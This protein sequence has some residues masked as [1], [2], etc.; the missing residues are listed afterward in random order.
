MKILSSIALSDNG[1]RAY[2]GNTK[3][4]IK[5]IMLP[6]GLYSEKKIE[7]TAFH[8]MIERELKREKLLDSKRRELKLK[9]K[10]Q[11]KDGTSESSTFKT[12]AQGR[13]TIKASGVFETPELRMER[14]EELTNT[15]EENLQKTKDAT[16]KMYAEMI[17]HVETLYMYGEEELQELKKD[18]DILPGDFPIVERM[19]NTL[20]E[21]EERWE[22]RRKGGSEK[23]YPGGFRQWFKFNSQIFLVQFL[24]QKLNIKKKV[25]IEIFLFYYC[26]CTSVE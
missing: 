9:K 15:Y 19:I 6:S 10:L 22:I 25:F 24:Y 4:V 2:I 11:Q 12:R 3:G 14:F 20:R 18:M 23:N 1:Q 16:Y 7:R 17:F 26:F 21:K 5:E 13:D 8:S